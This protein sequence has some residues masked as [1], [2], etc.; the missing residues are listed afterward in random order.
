[1]TQLPIFDLEGNDLGQF[2]GPD[3]VFGRKPNESLVHSCL[4]WYLASKRRGTHSTKTRAEV[5]GGGRKPWKQKG[6]GRARAG[7]IR[8]PLWRTGGVIFGPKPRSYTYAFPKKMRK[9]ALKSALSDKV[10]NGKF[11]IV[12][13]L[14]LTAAKTKTALAILK[15]LGV[16]G[17]SLIILEDKNEL[18]M[19]AARNIPGVKLI[20]INDLNI[21]DLIYSDWLVVEKSVL[22]KLQE[23]LN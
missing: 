18:F 5:S 1:M 20:Y 19:K 23:A 8:S 16:A 12:A 4:V 11:K 9:S 13:D 14:T 2:D 15:K 17:K 7:S 3:D 6:T 10:Q 22:A 21:F